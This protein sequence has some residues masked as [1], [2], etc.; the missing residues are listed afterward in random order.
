M[1]K[2]TSIPRRVL[3]I[4]PSLRSC[5]YAVIEGEGD[6]ARPLSLG[7]VKNKASLSLS[8][9]LENI[10]VHLLKVIDET[11]PVEC[12][13]EAVIYVQSYRTAITLG[14]A[15]GAALL[16]AR[17]RKLPIY[18]YAPRRVKQAVVGRGAADKQQVAFMIRALLGLDRT[19]APDEADA[20]AVGLTHLRSLGA[21]AL[22]GGDCKQI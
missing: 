12:A 1:S 10:H 14:G 13:M 21:A 19:P 22:L 3:A 16:A 20:L 7:T 17:L 8:E 2:R 15:R 18:E 5:G 4:D 11:E 6:R 9:C